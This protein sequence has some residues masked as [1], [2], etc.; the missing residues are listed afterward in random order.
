MMVGYGVWHQGSMAPRKTTRHDGGRLGSPTQVGFM[1]LW[2]CLGQRK[3]AIGS[4]MK[5]VDSI[6]CILGRNETSHSD[7]G[8]RRLAIGNIS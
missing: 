7:V 1:W 3:V 5:L 4:E 2:W 6:S 8:Q